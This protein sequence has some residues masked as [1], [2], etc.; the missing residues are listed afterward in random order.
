MTAFG[1]EPERCVVHLTKG[2]CFDQEL[3]TPD[4]TDWPMDAT[5]VL[6]LETDPVT[7]WAATFDGAKALLHAD[8]DPAAAIPGG[9][10]VTVTYTTSSKPVVWYVG[11]VTRHG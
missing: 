2:S 1:Y 11:V 8:P 3:D 10:K 6:D 4:G 7:S 9:T 5:I